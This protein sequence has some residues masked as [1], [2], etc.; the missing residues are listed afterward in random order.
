MS[1]ICSRGTLS[2]ALSFTRHGRVIASAGTQTQ[3]LR[4]TLM[5]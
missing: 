4:Y 5:R 1:E 3:A 2:R